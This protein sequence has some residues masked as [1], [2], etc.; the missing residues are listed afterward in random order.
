M[1]VKQV[2]REERVAP[3]RLARDTKPKPKSAEFVQ[4]VSAGYAKG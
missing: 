1:A 4:S 3:G 2:L